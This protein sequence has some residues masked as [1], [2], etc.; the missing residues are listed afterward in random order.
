MTRHPNSE[1][2]LSQKE[3]LLELLKSEKRGKFGKWYTTVDIMKRVY[4][5]G[6]TGIC[7]IASRVN[8]LRN[9][10]YYIESAKVKNG[11]TVWQ[12]R[13]VSTEMIFS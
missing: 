8:D 10:G 5:A 3:R 11:S 9:E 6:H 1:K 7:R 12:Y 4:G 2:G 13:L